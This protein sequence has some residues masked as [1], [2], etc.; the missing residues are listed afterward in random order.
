M[1]IGTN[2]RSRCRGDL[3]AAKR[4]VPERG[5]RRRLQADV[6][7]PPATGTIPEHVYIFGVVSSATRGCGDIGPN[8]AAVLRRGLHAINIQFVKLAP[9]ESDSMPI[10]HCAGRKAAE[11]L[12]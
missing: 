1:G 8:H 10:H 3:T 2:R 4:I 9:S 5:G 12:Y 6:A 11:S 7:G